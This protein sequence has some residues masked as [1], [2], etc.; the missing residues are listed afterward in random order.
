MSL[1]LDAVCEDNLEAAGCLITALVGHQADGRPG[2]GFFK[3]A[4]RKGF[5]T[6]DEDLFWLNQRSRALDFFRSAKSARPGLQ[7]VAASR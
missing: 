7:T 5:S 3:L 2:D 4:K 6:R 1:L